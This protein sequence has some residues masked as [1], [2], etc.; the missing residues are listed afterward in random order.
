MSGEPRVNIA[1]IHGHR[2]Y[3][4]LA[5]C[6]LCGS[7]FSSAGKWWQKVANAV[8]RAESGLLDHYDRE[9]KKAKS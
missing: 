9:H 8:K 4:A 1:V 7:S 2:G 3:Y 5:H 6:P